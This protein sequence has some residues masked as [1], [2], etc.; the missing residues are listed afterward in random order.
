MRQIKKVIKTAQ[1][2]RAKK[3]LGHTMMLLFN[4]LASLI[5]SYIFMKYF[6]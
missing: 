2:E 1:P 5:A 3:I 6:Q 4:V